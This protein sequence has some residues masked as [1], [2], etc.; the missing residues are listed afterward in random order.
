MIS[1]ETS[2]PTLKT[3]LAMLLPSFG[4]GIGDD[5]GDGAGGGHSR[6]A[7][8]DLGVG[9]AHAPLEVAVGGGQ[10]DVA[11]GEGP[12]VHAQA[13]AAAR[14]H[15]HGAGLHEGGNVALLQGLQVDAR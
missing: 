5:A 1:V 15:D 8:V 4:S 10:G 13:G 11:V 3:T 7:E 2:S 12:L 9:V 14:I 6:R